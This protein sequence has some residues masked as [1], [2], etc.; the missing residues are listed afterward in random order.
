MGIFFKVL[1]VT[2]K[3]DDSMLSADIWGRGGDPGACVCAKSL[4]DVW[5]CVTSMDCSPQGSSV[6]G[7]LQ[8]SIL[9]WVA[10]PSSRGFSLARDWT[11]VSYISFIGRQALL[12]PAPSGKP[13][14]LALNGGVWW[15]AHP[16]AY[17]WVEPHGHRVCV[18]LKV[19]IAWYES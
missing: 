13:R 12:P 11:H 14:Y 19:R 8:A 2:T 17:S 15:G 5:F 16:P 9:E 7:I 4:S 10:V 18:W 6:H 1:T 3:E